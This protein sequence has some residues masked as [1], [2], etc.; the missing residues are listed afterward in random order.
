M[1]WV[2]VK[3]EQAFIW[4]SSDVPGS[5][6][7]SVSKEKP[8]RSEPRAKLKGSVDKPAGLGGWRVEGRGR[9]CNKSTLALCLKSI[10]SAISH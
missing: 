10:V 1:I 6:G 3:R 9:Q 2:W 4:G 8:P 5:P 7:G